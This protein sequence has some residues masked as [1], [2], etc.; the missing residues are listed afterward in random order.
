[1]LSPQM[2]VQKF[3][4]ASLIRLALKFNGVFL[5]PN[6]VKLQCRIALDLYL[7]MLISCTIHLRQHK[8]LVLEQF[9][10]K[11]LIDGSQPLA[12]A[13][14]RRVY[15]KKDVLLTFDNKIREGSADNDLYAVIVVLW[16]WLS[17]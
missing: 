9:V 3:D 12:V 7:W 17:L 1:M 5:L 2:L 11:G 16:D 10:C 14:P 15:F 13:A 4:Q 6:L 8:V